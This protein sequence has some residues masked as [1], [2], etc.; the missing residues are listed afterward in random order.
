MFA[1][2]AMF[3]V[4]TGTI[5]NLVWQFNKRKTAGSRPI[6]FEYVPILGSLSARSFLSIPEWPNTE[7]SSTGTRLASSSTFLSARNSQDD[8]DETVTPEVLSEC[9]RSG[10]SVNAWLQ[11]GHIMLW[12]S[13]SLPENQLCVFQVGEVRTWEAVLTIHQLQL[14]HPSWTHWCNRQF[15]SDS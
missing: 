8:Y 14:V 15:W 4:Y 7:I 12:L 1:K 9:P 5:N 2:I 3:M 6:N 10:C 13:K 11:R